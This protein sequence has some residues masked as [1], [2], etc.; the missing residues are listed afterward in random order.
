M[1]ALLLALDDAD[2]QPTKPTHRPFLSV[3]SLDN[4]ETLTEAL[5]PQDAG[6]RACSTADR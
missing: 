3:I 2:Q 1:V 6:N 5:I 4:V